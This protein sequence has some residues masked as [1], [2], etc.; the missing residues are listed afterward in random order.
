MQ[1]AHGE[2][3][4]KALCFCIEPYDLSKANW[5]QEDGGLG[6]W[7]PVKR[8]NMMR[9]LDKKRIALVPVVSRL[10]FSRW[11]G[12]TCQPNSKNKFKIR[13]AVKLENT[14]AGGCL[15]SAGTLPPPW[16][17]QVL[18][19]APLNSNRELTTCPC[20]LFSPIKRVFHRA[21]WHLPWRTAS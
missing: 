17:T 4:S 12:T 2:Q 6:S 8:R 7:S 20:L 14:G 18:V 15:T 21:H 19:S 5:E 16:G 3:S 13:N 1:D 9:M 10:L 11:M